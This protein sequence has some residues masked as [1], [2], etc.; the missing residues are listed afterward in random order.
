MQL[1]ICS[2]IRS[3]PISNELISKLVKLTMYR[4]IGELASLEFFGR[5]ARRDCD[6]E[7]NA[8]AD[9]WQR[10]KVNNVAATVAV[11]ILFEEDQLGVLEL[12]YSPTQVASTLL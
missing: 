12:L 7:E 10:L 3:V 2:N 8:G 4:G 5:D 6:D 11:S 9:R 1:A